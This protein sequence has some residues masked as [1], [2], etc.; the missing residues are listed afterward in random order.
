MAVNG[1]KKGNRAERVLANWWQNWSGLEFSR[2]PQSGGLRWQ[3][4][5]DIS[6]DIICTSERESRRFPFSIESKS[7]NDLRFEHYIL[8]LTKVKIKDFWDQCST[9][10]IRSGKYPIL[11]MRYNNMRSS[12]WFVMMRFEE[13]KLLDSKAFEFPYFK[14]KTKDE[15]L[16]IMN[17]EDLGNTDYK[18]FIKK[19][20]IK[21]NG[22][23]RN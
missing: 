11:F 4:K 20:K 7:Y 21:R 1:K 15:I 2:V 18:T 3:K 16:V 23:K 6:G 17:S 10:A 13:F 14:V 19:I 5:D 12:T 8:G 22:E 9:D